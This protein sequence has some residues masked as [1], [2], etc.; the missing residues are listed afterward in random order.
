MLNYIQLL[1]Y[2]YTVGTYAIAIG[3]GYKTTAIGDYSYVE[4]Q[5]N[6]ASGRFGS[7]EV[8]LEQIIS[9]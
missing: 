4:G 9:S 6:I 7:V 5:Q 3:E 2:K 8:I 1:S